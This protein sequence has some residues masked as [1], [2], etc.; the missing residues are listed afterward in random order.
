MRG[1]GFEPDETSLRS[2]S[3]AQILPDRALSA[4]ESFAEKCAGPDLNLAETVGLAPLDRCDSSGSN[5]R[6]AFA[7]HELFAAKCAGPDLNREDSLRS[8][9]GPQIRSCSLLIAF[10]HARDRI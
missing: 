2:V 5:P 8:S 7:A 10:A 1:T 3:R 6:F 9:S 4:H